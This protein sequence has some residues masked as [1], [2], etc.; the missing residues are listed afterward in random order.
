MSTL[1]ILPAQ[2]PMLRRVCS[3]VRKVDKSIR[4]LLDDMTE[5]MDAADGLGLS[6][7]QVGKPLRAIVVRVGD[8]DLQLVNPEIVRS[9]GEEIAEEGCLSLPY[10][11]GP[12]A[13]AAEIT[14]QGLDRRGATIRR[15]AAGLFA[16]A[17]QHEIDHLQGI[18]FTD[19]LVDGAELRFAPPKPVNEGVRPTA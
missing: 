8:D 9:S 7:P 2:H 10:Y 19:K 5:S 12:V 13:R 1:P 15:K 14:V 11:Y 6:G 3:R 18:L 17:I 16:R 4:R